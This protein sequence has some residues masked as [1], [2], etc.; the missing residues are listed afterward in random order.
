MER[1]WISV[2][3]EEEKRGEKLGKRF[4]GNGFRFVSLPSAFK[5]Q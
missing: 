2:G 5:K 4:G 3:S 1:G